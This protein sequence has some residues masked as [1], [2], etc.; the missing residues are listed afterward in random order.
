MY[1]RQALSKPR[2]DGGALEPDRCH[3]GIAGDITLGE[4]WEWTSS[5]YLPYPGFETA[6]GAVGEYNGKFMHDQH[7]LRGGSAI[8]P[9]G[10]TRV[11]YR[12]FYPSHLRWMFAGLRLAR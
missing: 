1:K 6:P 9:A 10:H 4:V 3:P 11:T 5:A 2:V 7:V 8:T 12:N